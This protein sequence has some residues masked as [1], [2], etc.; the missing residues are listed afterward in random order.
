MP[1]LT[2]AQ[3]LSTSSLSYRLYFPNLRNFVLLPVLVFPSYCFLC[4]KWLVLNLCSPNPTISVKICSIPLLYASTMFLWLSSVMKWLSTKLWQTAAVN[5][6]V[7]SLADCFQ[8]FIHVSENIWT[9]N[10]K[11]YF[12]FPTV[13]V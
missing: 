6:K 8:Q 4:L 7:K 12:S 1:C 10:L 9:V 2:S 11:F 13:L 3:S 5:T